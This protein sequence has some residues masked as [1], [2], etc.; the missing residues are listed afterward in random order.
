MPV[1]VADLLRGDRALLG[2]EHGDRG[3]GEVDHLAH[4]ACDLVAAEKL[5]RVR[6]ER[7]LIL[8]E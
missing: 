1:V 7:E 8:S 6:I 5:R 3:F 4:A 2:G